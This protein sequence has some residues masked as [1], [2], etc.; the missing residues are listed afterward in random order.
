MAHQQDADLFEALRDAN[1]EALL[2][3]GFERAYL[4]FTV[5]QHHAVVAVYDYAACVAI[6]VERD[7]VDE[8]DAEEHLSFNTLSAYVGEHT[9]L[10]IK[11]PTMERPV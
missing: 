9:P 7:G 4:G 1:P 11:R 3:D 2:A 8:L 5:N 10:F 6:L